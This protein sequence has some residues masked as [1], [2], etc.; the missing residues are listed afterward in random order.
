[1]TIHQNNTNDKLKKKSI[2]QRMKFQWDRESKSLGLKPLGDPNLQCY[3]L[4]KQIRIFDFQGRR[5]LT[6]QKA[7]HSHP[8]A[9]EDH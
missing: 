2:Y 7:C 3:L 1:M 6:K 8:H 9:L 5:L 4:S